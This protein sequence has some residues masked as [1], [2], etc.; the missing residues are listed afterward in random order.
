[1]AAFVLFMSGAAP[2]EDRTGLPGKYKF[3]LTRFGTEEIPTS[4]WDLAPLG[5]RLIPVKIPT[6]NEVIDHNIERPSPN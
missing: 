2:I 5:L 1:M 4:D 6:E 3:D